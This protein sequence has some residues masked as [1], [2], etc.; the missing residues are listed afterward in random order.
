MS[1][2][3]IGVSLAS[4]HL[5]DWRRLMGPFYPPP[6]RVAVLAAEEEQ[7]GKFKSVSD[8]LFFSVANDESWRECVT[9]STIHSIQRAS[10]L[11]VT[12]VLRSTFSGF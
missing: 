9:K 6:G 8:F 1:V 4:L 2:L 5:A 11:P 10:L 7:L 12:P 3:C